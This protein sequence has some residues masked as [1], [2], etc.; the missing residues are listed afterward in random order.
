MAKLI[1]KQHI[2]NNTL[3]IALCDDNLVNKVFEE[4]NKQI[5]LTGSYFDGEIVSKEIAQ[6]MIQ[7]AKSATIVGETAT[8]IAKKVFEDCT[9]DTIDSIPIITVFR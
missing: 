5:D 6:D 8:K 3:M 7:K 4:G 9:I 1:L 2:R